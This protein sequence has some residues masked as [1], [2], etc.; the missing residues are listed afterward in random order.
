MQML[1]VGFSYLITFPNSRTS[2][3]YKLLTVHKAKENYDSLYTFLDKDGMKVTFTKGVCKNL[4]AVEWHVSNSVFQNP[5]Y[6]EWTID[7]DELYL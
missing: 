4:T 2:Y 6:Q 7:M 5:N 3:L 1:R